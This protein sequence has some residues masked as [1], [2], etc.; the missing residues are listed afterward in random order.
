VR[1]ITRGD[2][3]T[4]DVIAQ[5]QKGIPPAV[6]FKNETFIDGEVFEKLSPGEEYFGI[7]GYQEGIRT[8]KMQ[9]QNSIS[10]INTPYQRLYLD[11]YKLNYRRIVYENMD[12]AE[13]K[14]SK[15]SSYSVMI[16]TKENDYQKMVE[17]LKQKLNEALVY[18]SKLG[19]KKD[20]VSVIR[21]IG[22]WDTSLVKQANST[23]KS[24]STKSKLYARSQPFGE[25]VANY[26]ENFGVVDGIVLDE[27][28][29]TSVVDINFDWEPESVMAIEGFLKKLGLKLEKAVREY[30]VLIIYK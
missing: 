30:D 15:E 1:A 9:Y 17:S 7:K 13:Q 3:L 11:L 25:A 19:K 5:V 23:V 10:Y 2:E 6:S 8:S 4:E 27:T 16:A 21:K 22:E 29:D 26:L 20:T 28:G 14:I 18:K 24:N 12:P